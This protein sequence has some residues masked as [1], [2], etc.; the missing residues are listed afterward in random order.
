MTDYDRMMTRVVE[1]L[2]CWLFMGA[3][4]T[5]GYG[6]VRSKNQFGRWSC[7]T[8]HK[9]AYEHHHGSVPEGLVVRHMCNVRN[10]VNPEHLTVGTHMENMADLRR[11]NQARKGGSYWAEYTDVAPF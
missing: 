2:D 1:E 9:L 3:R 11:A 6:N 4:H 5:N 8:A 7:K 10:C